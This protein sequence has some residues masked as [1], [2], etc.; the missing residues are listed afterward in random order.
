MVDSV[1]GQ[2]IVR[3]ASRHIVRGIS[4]KNATCR[5]SFMRPHEGITDLTI[6]YPQLNLHAPLPCTTS[7]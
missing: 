4:V 7:A 5:G 1:E 2:L 6:S 3:L